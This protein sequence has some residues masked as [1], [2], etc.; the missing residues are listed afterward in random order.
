M[1]IYKAVLFVHNS[2]LTLRGLL[3]VKTI[4]RVVFSLFKSVRNVNSSRAGPAK[5]RMRIQTFVV[6]PKIN[7]DLGQPLTGSA[8]RLNFRDLI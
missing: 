5:P 1:E 2:M 8:Q 7:D 3:A 6:D 4:G